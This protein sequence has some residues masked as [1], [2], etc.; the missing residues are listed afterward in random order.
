MSAKR[1]IVMV[2]AGAFAL[3][4]T[5]AGCSSSKSGSST[6]TT[7][8]G[9][10]SSSLNVK[11][12]MPV[13]DSKSF[14]TELVTLGE[15]NPDPSLDA[16]GATEV[17][18][19]HGL[20]ESALFGYGKTATPTNISGYT[21]VVDKGERYEAYAFA[22]SDGKSCTYGVIYT[23]TAGSVPTGKV[24]NATGACTGSAALDEFE[25]S[26]LPK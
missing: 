23:T 7:A 26:V 9:S 21:T 3:A 5:L 24:Y 17:W 11:L 14:T 13:T 4:L 2:S 16:F 8:G 10:G 12:T 15:A 22:V 20:P 25:N 6:T 1:T 19:A 18:M